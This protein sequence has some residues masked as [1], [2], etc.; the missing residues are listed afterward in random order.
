MDD[1]D[2]LLQKVNLH[3][4]VDS[5]SS[6]NSERSNQGTLCY[7]EELCH[8]LAGRTFE[9]QLIGMDSNGDG[10]LS[11][12]WTSAKRSFI[13]TKGLADSWLYGNQQKHNAYPM[14]MEAWDS[15]NSLY[16]HQYKVKNAHDSDNDNLWLTWKESSTGKALRFVPDE[17]NASRIEFRDFCEY[18]QFVECQG[19]NDR[20]PV[21]R[22][23]FKE[24]TVENYNA[25]WRHTTYS[26]RIHSQYNSDEETVLLALHEEEDSIGANPTDMVLHD[27]E[28]P[29]L[30]EQRA[31]MVP[32][33]IDQH[34]C[35]NA[36][37]VYEKFLCPTFSYT[38]VITKAET[39]CFTVTTGLS[40]TNTV[41]QSL[42]INSSVPTPSW[43]SNP[44]AV[45]STTT[46]TSS[47][48]ATHTETENN[49]E[50]VTTSENYQ[51]TV[52]SQTLGPWSAVMN[53]LSRWKGVISDLP[54]TGKLT[55]SYADGRSETVTVSGKFDS[56]QISTVSYGTAWQMSKTTQKEDGTNYTEEEIQTACM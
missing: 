35:C 26:M 19:I 7:D 23:Q 34:I 17:V 16:C 20:C 21:Y 54:W 50:T 10:T 8:P 25:S 45:E 31:A 52:P 6:R 28:F 3:N 18:E 51:E 13:G 49:C 30:N 37:A 27:I 12:D 2:A 9:V 53:K 4:H 40:S 42:R 14:I 55:S 38:E 39:A 32:E 1:E 43:A 15:S 47:V 44:F 48:T 46:L 24:D 5:D 22:W 56:V 36:G 33:D 29:D 41:S 11:T